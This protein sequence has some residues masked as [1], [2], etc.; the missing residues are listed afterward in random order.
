MG[1]N[2]IVR[3]VLGVLCFLVA[4]VGIK[5]EANGKYLMYMPFKADEKWY[6]VQGNNSSYTHTGTL[7]Y[8][9]DFN[10]GSGPNGSTNPAYGRSIVS[11]V[12]GVVVD[13]RTGAPD[14]SDNEGATPTNNNGWGN[15]LLIRDDVTG[16]FVRFAHMRN[17]SVNLAVGDIVKLGQKIGEIGQSGWS[18]GPHLHLHMQE[19]AAGGS[20]SVQFSFV[21]GPITEGSWAYSELGLMSFVLDDFSGMSLSHGVKSYIG[22]MSKGWNI[23]PTSQPNTSTGDGSYYVKKTVSNPKPWYKC[24]FTMKSTAFYAVYV[25]YNC[26]SKKDTAAQ[27]DFYSYDDPDIETTIYIDQSNCPEHYW[28]YLVT[29]LFRADKTYYIK[30]MPTTKLSYIAAD[31]LQ[32]VKLWPPW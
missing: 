10:Q 5:G 26:T 32:F 21:E 4:A 9:Y 3:A 16:M 1:K 15:T 29:T 2:A 28:Q 22:Y 24:V 17:G 14:F 13:S 31:G 19:G 6:C 12:R 8:A 23:Y 25:K 27:Y 7:K 30:L 11:P 18:S 20:Q